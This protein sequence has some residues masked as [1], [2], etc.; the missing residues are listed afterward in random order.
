MSG[1]GGFR[2]S[3]GS[4]ERFA[5]QLEETRKQVLANPDL[6][7]QE[8]QQLL[9]QLDVSGAG[10]KAQTEEFPGLATT[11]RSRTSDVAASVRKE[12]EEIGTKAKKR[13]TKFRRFQQEKRNILLDRPGTR[14]T[15][16]TT[17]GGG[18]AASGGGSLITG[19]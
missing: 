4:S 14:Q 18:G 9:S 13:G 12:L 1:G 5:K 16:L 10:G 15:I 6:N 19:L 3:V 2:S 8:R 17:R 11:E 7:E